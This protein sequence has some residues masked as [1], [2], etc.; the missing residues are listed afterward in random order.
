MEIR[1]QWQL[2]FFVGIVSGLGSIAME[3]GLVEDR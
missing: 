2:A 3:N 1:E